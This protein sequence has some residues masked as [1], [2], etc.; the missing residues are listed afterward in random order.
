MNICAANYALSVEVRKFI[1]NVGD[2]KEESITDYLVWKWRELDKRFNYL[3]VQPFNH[4]EESSTTGADFD[5]ELWLVSSTFQVSLAVQAKKFIKRSD[6]YVK[7]LRY[8][9]GT[10]AQMDKLL[11][12][13]KS[14]GRSPFYFIYTIPQAT[15]NPMCDR[16]NGLTPSVEGGAIF[17]ADAFVMEEYADGKHGTR[18]S[19]DQ[20][21][22][23]SNPFHCMFCCPLAGSQE[24]FRHYFPSVSDQATERNAELPSYARRLLIA[25]RGSDRQGVVLEPAEREQLRAFRAVGVYDMRDDA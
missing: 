21:L 12:H 16:K 24:Y 14:Q 11:A 6:S 5:L 10:K 4:D 20:L 7:R 17:M 25:L 22:R 15:T 19:R 13:A 9:N 1:E 3:R 18:V 8:P 23:A 2:A